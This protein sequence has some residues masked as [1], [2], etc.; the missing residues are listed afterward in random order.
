MRLLNIGMREKFII[1][2]VINITR[3]VGVLNQLAPL[4][5]KEQDYS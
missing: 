2:N 3:V 4:N 1:L 5:L